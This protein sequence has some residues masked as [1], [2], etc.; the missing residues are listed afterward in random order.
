MWLQII[1]SI[2]L[3]A[4]ALQFILYAAR[5]ELV[6]VLKDR[7][8]FVV[9]NPRV[10][11]LISIVLFAL[12]GSFVLSMLIWQEWNFAGLAA[13]GAL[14]AA[15]VYSWLLARVW[16]IEVRPE[17]LVCVST[18][19]VKRL[20]HFEDIESAVVSASRIVL[21][22]PVK[23]FKMSSRVMYGEDLLSQLGTHHVPIYRD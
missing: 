1:L 3:A 23:T 5:H 9:R 18:L 21:H 6:P 13:T 4:A 22:T 17:Y 2:I 10:V 11:L 14:L 7:Q 12:A 16:H 8:N 19:G 20:V 15:G